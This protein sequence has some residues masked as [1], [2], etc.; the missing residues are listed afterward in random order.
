MDQETETDLREK[1]LDLEARLHTNESDFNQQRS[2]FKSILITHESELKLQLDKIEDL[3]SENAAFRHQ[4]DILGQEHKEAHELLQLSQTMDSQEFERLKTNLE[5]EQASL[6]QS[7]HLQLQE[8]QA[9]LQ[10]ES[11][12]RA[13][14]LKERTGLIQEVGKLRTALDSLKQQ[15]AS[16][17]LED[18][19]SRAQE[20]SFKLKN[21]VLPLETEIASLK[22]QLEDA[23][24]EVPRAAS[25]T[26]TPQ[27]D[28]IQFD[29]DPPASVPTPHDSFLST[30]LS[31]EDI[32]QPA[33][34]PGGSGGKGDEVFNPLFD[35]H[36]SVGL[37]Q[38]ILDISQESSEV[39][40]RREEEER[41]RGLEGE[42]RDCQMRC[43]KYEGL[44]DE[45]RADKEELM[46]KNGSLTYHLSSITRDMNKHRA[47]AA[48]MRDLVAAVSEEALTQRPDRFPSSD[49]EQVQEYISSDLASTPMASGDSLL[50]LSPVKFSM[51]EGRA[52][53]TGGKKIEELEKRNRELEEDVRA[54]QAT[55]SSGPIESSQT[56]K[57]MTFL[58]V[59]VDQQ[60]QSLV[61]ERKI[62]VD[63]KKEFSHH[64]SNIM[65]LEEAYSDKEIGMNKQ[66]LEMRD[67]LKEAKS[68]AQQQVAALMDD[69]EKL[70]ARI[71]QIEGGYTSLE[72]QR[73]GEL[74]G[75]SV[76]LNEEKYRKS[77]AE[78]NVAALTDQLS[79]VQESKQKQHSEFAGKLSL[80]TDQI[81]RLQEEKQSLERGYAEEVSG[82][83]KQLTDL[84]QTKKQLEIVQNTKEELLKENQ[85]LEGELMERDKEKRTLNEQLSNERSVLAEKE[86]AFKRLKTELN[87]NEE[88]QRDFVQL[89]QQL[90][91]QVA[92]LE[93]ERKVLRWEF[94]DD[95]PQCRN[96][97]Q[98]FSKSHKKHRCKHCCMLFCSECSQQV[99]ENLQKKEVRVCEACYKLIDKP[100][101]VS[102]L[103]KKKRSTSVPQEQSKS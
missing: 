73:E 43:A 15:K 42:V 58:K 30:I 100:T 21:L 86:S 6:R 53:D 70:T 82:L 101:F 25:D 57:Q 88:V 52:E 47:M 9:Q 37:V 49:W 65:S 2:K 83:K 87:T 27:A 45:L 68:D 98:V 75:Y 84:S 99:A 14:W 8:Y 55:R 59:I 60:R 24:R 20:E 44:L 13:K 32:E 76:Q 63:M 80:K 29:T 3:N 5:Q 91:K 67:E 96:C 92:E 64:L 22:R 71:H 4:L 17:T 34:N 74:K 48:R 1:I 77:E 102:S 50:T 56:Q 11:V 69:R 81:T 33:D 7:F 89:S 97:S 36:S 31:T 79:S 28:L 93:D 40:S 12:Q 41:L 94:E 46:D 23:R 78:N 19:M 85:R 18:E 35:T 39:E 62:R 95:I 26:R 10:L 51:W 103:S 54:L 90:Q 72:S 38:Q 66:L 61:K 16:G